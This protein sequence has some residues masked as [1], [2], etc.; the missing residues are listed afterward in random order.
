MSISVSKI[1]K[2]WDNRAKEHTS[3][4]QG[5][6]NDLYL[7]ELEIKTVSEKIR[8]LGLS[9]GASLIDIGCGD[10]YST[11]R[12]AKALPQAINVIIYATFDGEIQITND[13]EIITD[14]H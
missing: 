6:T 13:R 2:Y 4:C 9:Y 10:G 14:A 11:M 5:T 8:G 7:R 1:K 12:F 3:D